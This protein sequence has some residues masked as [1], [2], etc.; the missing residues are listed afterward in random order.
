MCV[1][2][3]ICLCHFVIDLCFHILM[4]PLPYC[5]RKSV[6]VVVVSFKCTSVEMCASIRT[7]GESGR[8][9]ETI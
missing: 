3:C 7:V 5:S 9:K 6:K 2:V 1:G 8:V 4:L